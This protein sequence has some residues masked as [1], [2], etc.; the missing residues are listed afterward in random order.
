MAPDQPAMGNVAKPYKYVC[1][2][3]ELAGGYYATWGVQ[4]A[5]APSPDHCAGGGQVWRRDAAAAASNSSAGRPGGISLPS[6]VLPGVG[7]GPNARANSGANRVPH[8][9]ADGDTEMGS[10]AGAA[11]GE[12]PNTES[13]GQNAESGRAVDWTNVFATC[14]QKYVR[15]Y[16]ANKGAKPTMLQLYVDPAEDEQFY[17]VSWTFNVIGTGEWWLVAAGARGVLRVFNISVGKL[18]KTMIGHGESINCAMTHPRDPALILTASKDESLRLWN[19]RTSSTVAIFAGL[20]GHRGE[21]LYADFNYTGTH[22]ASCGIDNSIRVWEIADDEKVMK[23]IRST[24][25]AADQGITDVCVYKDQL[26][27]RRKTVVP[28]VQFPKFATLKVHKHYV[29]CVMWVGD[30]LVSKSLQNRILLWEPRGDREALA[31]PASYFTVLEE[32]M[33]ENCTSWFIRFGLD[34]SRRL[35]ACGNEVGVVTVY[36]L[37]QIPSKALCVLKCEQDRKKA[38]NRKLP[39]EEH[40][41]PSFCVRQCAFSDDASILLTV[42]ESSCIVQYERV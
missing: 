26:G 36:Q 40:R 3:Q 27:Q 1:Y 13:N 37:N 11:S 14:C 24:H 22:F 12:M 23:A 29:D 42:D 21:V 41:E 33:L 20:R 28:M 18:E 7:S 25:S 39:P 35:V 16:K 2:T 9:D 38:M 4:F 6:G 30:L 15:I 32:Y 19:L 8:V 10:G 31:S 5:L 17:T 34:R